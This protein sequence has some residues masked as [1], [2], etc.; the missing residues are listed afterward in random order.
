MVEIFGASERD[1]ASVP[2]LADYDSNRTPTQF[3][4][5]RIKAD[6]ALQRDAT[7]VPQFTNVPIVPREYQVHLSAAEC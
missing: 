4:Q 6:R 3:A 2:L 5:P 1:L 7:Y